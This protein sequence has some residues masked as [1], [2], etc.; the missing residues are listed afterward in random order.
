MFAVC[1][2]PI[3]NVYFLNGVALI[4]YTLDIRMTNPGQE[5]QMLQSVGLCV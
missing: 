2:S 1:H 3:I 5:R 4:Q